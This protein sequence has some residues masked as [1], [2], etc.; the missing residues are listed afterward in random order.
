MEQSRIPLDSAELQLLV[1]Q[2]PT[3][4][5]QHINTAALVSSIEESSCTE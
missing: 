3:A 4:E 1:Q 5:D 2:W